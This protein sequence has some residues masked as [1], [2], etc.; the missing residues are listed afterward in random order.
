MLF[1]Y[2]VSP[3]PHQN[4]GRWS[5]Q[6]FIIIEIFPILQ[7]RLGLIKVELLVQGLIGGQ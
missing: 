4:S 7:M 2:T 6:I 5:G 3:A 1:I